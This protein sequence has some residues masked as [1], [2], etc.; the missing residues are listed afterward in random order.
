MLD[1]TFSGFSMQAVAGQHRHRRHRGDPEDFPAAVQG[2]FGPYRMLLL[3][4]DGQKA[5]LV[6]AERP[7]NP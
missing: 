4:A 5:L 1:W 2:S 7:L 3:C 6:K